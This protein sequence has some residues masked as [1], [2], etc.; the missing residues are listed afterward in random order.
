V[1]TGDETYR[2][3]QGCSSHDEPEINPLSD[4]PGSAENLNWT[5]VLPTD[6]GSEVADTGPTF[7]FGGLVNEP[8]SEFGQAFVELQFYPDALL[9]KCTGGGG[10]Q[11]VHAPNTDTACSPVWSVRNGAEPAAFNAM[12][13]DASSSAPLVMHVG[14]TITVHFLVTPA[15]EG[16]H[17]KV[18]DLVTGHWGRS[19]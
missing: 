16:W 6:Q 13:R 10:F 19:C 1:L 9:T 5:V 2:Y 17:T 3:K 8:R 14:G 15:K 4:R 7:W 11:V 12:L 18:T